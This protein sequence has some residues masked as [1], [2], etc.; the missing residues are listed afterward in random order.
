M[1]GMLHHIQKAIIDVLAGKDPARYADLK[2]ADMDGNQFTYHLKQ[3]ITA[4]MVAQNEDGTY[5]LTKT[6]QTYLIRRYEDLDE[7]AHTIFL[8]VIRHDNKLLLR[9]RLVQPSLG[10]VGFVHGEPVATKPLEESV[11]E[12]VKLKT[13]LDVT[14]MTVHGSGL[15]RIQA[16][17]RIES[18]SHAI[19]VSTTVASE[20]LPIAQDT[21]G[22]NF[23]ADTSTLNSIE[24]LLPSCND[25]LQGLDDGTLGWF[26]LSYT[27]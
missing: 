23:W 13:G 1:V 21:T 25:I 5:S 8:V 19:I 11:A 9:Q 15:I 22:H 3:L 26:N 24:H 20:D 14:D 7:A 2:P 12:R 18:F 17:D 4:K 27:L 16:N 10:T 6:G